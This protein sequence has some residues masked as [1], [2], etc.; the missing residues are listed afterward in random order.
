MRRIH[1]LVRK[2]PR[3][4]YRLIT[5]IL[6]QEGWRVNFKRIYR[7]WPQEWLGVHKK[8]RKK[9]RIGQSD[10]S[11]SRRRAEHKDHA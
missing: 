3:Y 10:N 8:T 4:G 7:L 11:C 9:L 5:E 6:R 1:E 2:Y